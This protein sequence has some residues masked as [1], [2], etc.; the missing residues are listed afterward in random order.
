MLAILSILGIFVA[1]ILVHEL[2]HFLAAKR[3]GM[4]VEEFG[5]FFPPRILTFKK[6]ETVYSL[7]LIPLGGF[8]KIF[9]EQGQHKNNPRSF[10]AKSLGMRAI[11]ISAGVLMN[12]VLAA[13][14]F[15]WGLNIGMPTVATSENEAQL[16]QVVIRLVE[17]QPDGPAKEVGL[18]IGDQL[19]SIEGQ[20][21]QKIEDLQSFV[22]ANTGKVLNVAVKRGSEIF[23]FKVL[24][25]ANPPEGQGP[26]GVGLAR[27]GLEKQPFLTALG[28][29][30]VLTFETLGAVAVGFYQLIVSLLVSGRLI[31]EVAGPVGIGSLAF[32][33][34]NLGLPFF[35][36]FA[37]VLSIS[38]AVINAIP[39]PAL[40]GGRLI[41]LGWEGL[42]G[43]RVSPKVEQMVH[44]AGFIALILLIVIIT[45]RDI[46]R[47]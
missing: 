29:G 27:I 10:A 22:Q 2:G 36:R 37:G 47:F 44:A 33:F 42:S 40:D 25:R 34:Y 11:V 16:E 14:F 1:L 17:V 12:L 31:G 18:R 23:N 41:F 32:Q 5:I 45:F 13:L 20:S 15:A 24:A 30:I 26:M 21:F 4:K 9:G 39:F 38:L 35:L 28:Q 6:G 19:Q 43:R 8:V 3:A 7:N 46:S